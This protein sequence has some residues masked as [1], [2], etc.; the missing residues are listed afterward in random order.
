MFS[1]ASLSLHFLFKMAAN[2]KNTVFRERTR[3]EPHLCM[4][5]FLRKGTS[6]QMLVPLTQTG[7]IYAHIRLTISEQININLSGTHILK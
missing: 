4:L 1:L 5:M 2:F 6:L 7:T 3:F